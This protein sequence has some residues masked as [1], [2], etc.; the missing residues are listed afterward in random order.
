MFNSAI[1]AKFTLW[2]LPSGHLLVALDDAAN[3]VESLLP[4][5]C[6]DLLLGIYGRLA[7]R[8]QGVQ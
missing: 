5:A 4:F 7:V 3:A 2:H 8:D 1:F 6:M